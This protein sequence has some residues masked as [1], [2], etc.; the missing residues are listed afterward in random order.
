M[1]IARFAVDGMEFHGK[2]EGDSLRVIKG[3]IYEDFG[4]SGLTYPLS[5]VKLLA[6]TKPVTYWGVGENYAKHVNYRM[7]EMG[8]SFRPRAAAFTPWH[9]GVGSL[10]GTGDTIIIPPD[11][12]WIEYEGEICVV[13]GKPCFRVTEEQAPD[14]ILGYTVT[15]DIGTG[16]TWAR[17]DFSL[18]RVKSCDTFGPAGPWIE[19]EVDPHGVDIIVRVDGKEEDRGN[20]RD[21]I[22]NCYEIVS[23][24][25]RHM[26]LHPGD[27]ITT[28]APGLTRPLKDGE[29]IE[30]EIPEIGVLRNPIAALKE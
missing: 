25:S 17:S 18:W 13:I 8:E 3:S 2:V 4:L 20:T 30:V 16:P 7:E 5:R 24:I 23:R 1:K 12:D 6:P 22:H 14:Y 29:V 27:L 28:G 9:K 10:I 26:T 21:M 11:A 15:N 19:T